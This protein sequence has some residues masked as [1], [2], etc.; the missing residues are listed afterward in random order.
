ML[1][2]SI[3]EMTFHP[4]PTIRKNQN[5]WPRP[6]LA[7]AHGVEKLCIVAGSVKSSIGRV[8]TVHSVTFSASTVSQ[9]LNFD[10]SSSQ[11]S[12]IL[13]D[14]PTAVAYSSRTRLWHILS[15]Q[16]LVTLSSN[17]TRVVDL[18]DG[19][20]QY[21]PCSV[22]RFVSSDSGMYFRFGIVQ[23][24]EYTPRILSD[25]S[26]I[27]ASF[28]DRFLQWDPLPS[29]IQADGSKLHYR[30][31]EGVF[32]YATPGD[33][34]AFVTVKFCIRE[35]PPGSSDALKAVRIESITRIG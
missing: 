21:P 16:Y 17:A 22:A 11:L 35:P 32:D 18:D 7:Y 24:S 26:S 20:T 3:I 34:L 2:P 23:L 33:Y 6:T 12:P 13:V 31:V 9:N 30:L 8:L 4:F 5:V 27:E 15:L 25:N 28:R 29:V 10:D 19:E 1:S 14:D